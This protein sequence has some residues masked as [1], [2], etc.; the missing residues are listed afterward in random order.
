MLK[1][2]Q[3]YSALIDRYMVRHLVKPGVTGWAQV[4][5][6]RG[7]THELWEMEGRVKLDIWYL[8]HWTFL[9]DLYIIYRTVKNGFKGEEKA[10]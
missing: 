3:E 5:G 2:T 10:Y 8:E 7:E 9:L 6:F 1:H 4:N